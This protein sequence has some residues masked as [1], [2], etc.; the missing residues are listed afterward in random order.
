MKSFSLLLCNE[1]EN[2][3]A[4]KWH[5]LQSTWAPAELS[6]NLEGWPFCLQQNGNHVASMS[7][8]VSCTPHPTDSLSKDHLVMLLG[9]II[10]ASKPTAFKRLSC[11]DWLIVLLAAT[12]AAPN[13]CLLSTL[14]LQSGSL[15]VPKVA[16][17]TVG[18]RAPFC[19]G[20]SQQPACPS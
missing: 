11:Y 1:T 16:P 8:L 15:N 14:L 2:E 10:L 5:G 9:S 17:T 3:R 13:L 18:M 6:E 7:G 4:S 12:S 19:S 20:H